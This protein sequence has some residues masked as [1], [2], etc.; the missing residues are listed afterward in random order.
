MDVDRRSCKENPF[1][2]VRRSKGWGRG[3]LRW[4]FL[5]SPGLNSGKLQ[6]WNWT[7]AAASLTLFFCCFNFRGTQSWETH[8]NLGRLKLLLSSRNTRKSHPWE[9]E[10]IAGNHG[11]EGAG[12]KHPLICVWNCRLIFELHMYGTG[13][14]QYSKGFEN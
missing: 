9:S 8:E 6:W 10:S 12:E 5:N 7:P 11:E 13:Q 14:N 3:A 4:S 2:Q 1:S